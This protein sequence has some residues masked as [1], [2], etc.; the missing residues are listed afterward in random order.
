LARRNCNI[1]KFGKTFSRELRKPSKLQKLSEAEA[2]EQERPM[3][4]SENG[5]KHEN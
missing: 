2:M 5:E 1:Y 3:G 4:P